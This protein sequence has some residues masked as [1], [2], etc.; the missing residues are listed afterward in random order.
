MS[1]N[2]TDGERAVL[3]QFVENEKE[4][5]QGAWNWFHHS[6]VKAGTDAGLREAE[7]DGVCRNLRRRKLLTGEGGGKFATYYPSDRGR[8]VVSGD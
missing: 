1:V 5:A 3:K 7:I 6:I 2:L 8:E 4:D